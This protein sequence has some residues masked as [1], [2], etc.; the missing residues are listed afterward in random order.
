MSGQQ[1]ALKVSTAIQ[2]E[3]GAW[4][5]T[6]TMDTPMGQAIDT[7][8]LDRTSLVLRKRSVKQGAT[9][10]DLDFAGDKAHG[11]MNMNGQERPVSVDLG[12]PLF[13]DSNGA[14]QAIGCLPL[15]DG[16]TTTFRNLD[17]MKQKVKVM[18]LKVAGSE[19]VTVPAG[20]FDTFKVELTPADGG[21]D[22]STI[23]F[24]KDSRK[25]VK[26]SAVLSEMGGATLTTELIP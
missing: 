13:A 19:S 17:L 22:K 7:A 26:M 3:N 8:T 1:I 23:W 10:I 15:A 11:T 2:E 9:S 6:S 25:L 5:A 18:E 21:P 14:Q 20:T 24:A 12:G 4:T 16:Y